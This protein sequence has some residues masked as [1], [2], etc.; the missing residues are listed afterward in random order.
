MTTLLFLLW[1]CTAGAGELPV[2]KGYDFSSLKVEHRQLIQELR[3]ASGLT[4][5]RDGRLLCHNDEQGIIYEIDYRTGSV[6]QRFYLGKL[7][8]YQD[9]LEGIAAKDDTIFIVNS[10]GK[11]LRFLPGKNEEKISFE[12]FKT[13]L[14]ARNNVE[15][16]AYDPVTDCLLLACKDEAAID[17][18][19]PLAA[20]LKAV[21][22]FSLKTYK[23]LPKPRFLISTSKITARTGKR[24]SALLPLNVIR[25]PGI[26]RFSRKGK[27]QLSKW[28]EWQSARRF[29]LARIR[30]SAAGGRGDCTRLDRRDLQ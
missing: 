27:G 16:L 25:A 2:I 5:T 13:P 28:I 19:N 29:F 10:S 24:I 3:E 23:L 18:R 8:V 4:F 1:S 15:G 22:A 9:D 12:T 11:I 30:A 14:T 7:T 20:D 21:Y 6:R 17:F 26:F